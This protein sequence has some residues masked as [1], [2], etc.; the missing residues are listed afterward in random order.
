MKL[1]VDTDAFCKLGLTGLLADT[2]KIFEVE[3]DDCGRLPALPQMLRKG[4]LRK[5][6]GE[7]ACDDLISDAEAIP[8]IHQPNVQWLDKLVSIS[9]IDP[10]E[11]QIFAAAAESSL[12]VL[13]GDKRALRALK[14]LDDFVNA[15]AGRVVVLEAVFIRLCDQIGYQQLRSR[16][17]PLFGCDKVVDICFSAGNS[18]PRACLVSYYES[19]VAEVDPL[20]L[21]HPAAGERT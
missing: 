6:Y 7:K 19:L 20:I 2:L 16:I 3:L 15:L 9:D 11:T 1:L 5:L 10:G 14:G 13:S 4:R 8:V 12:I 21:W 17:A 18:D